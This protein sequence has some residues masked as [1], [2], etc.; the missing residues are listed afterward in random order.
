MR[1]FTILRILSGIIL[2]LTIVT[3]TVGLFWQD[4]GNSFY[5]ESVYGENIKMF[6]NGLYSHESFFKAPINKGTDAVTLF[7]VVP[8]FLSV[9]LLNSRNSLKL[10]LLYL[11]LLSYLLYYSASLAFGASYNNFFVIYI[12]LFST[13][14]YGFIIGIIDIDT[15]IIEDK[16]MPGLP[17]R[18]VAIFMF[19]AGLSVFVW[20]IEILGSIVNG[21]PPVSLGINTTEPTFVLD[22]GI[23]APSAFIGGVS[24]LK[25]KP[26][27][28]I[29]A[30]ILLT[31]N[32]LIG[33][34]V[35]S[36]SIFQKIYGVNIGFEQFITYV[37][38]F[39]LMSLIATTLNIQVLRN[40][41]H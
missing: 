18:A 2:L 17:H 3:T 10:R 8:L 22:L 15:K 26:F 32:A 29:V 21:N 14:L 4:G 31:L 1:T 36:Q 28:Y 5:V 25:R 35:I 11:G 41:K 19:F 33:L 9:V 16:I 27:G 34:V 38:I 20:L 23:I 40:I 24:I 7:I 12:L 13:S 39:V 37:G 6:G 30:S